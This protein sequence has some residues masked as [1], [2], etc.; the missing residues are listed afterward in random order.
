ME[1]IERR[2]DR[3]RVVTMYTGAGAV[4]YGCERTNDARRKRNDR[5]AG[6]DEDDET[7]DDATT[8]SRSRDRVERTTDDDRVFT[9]S[10]A[11]SR[12]CIRDSIV[13]ARA[14]SPGLDT[15]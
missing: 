9:N 5:P 4:D 8:E 15:R 13:R 3:L 12:A 1:P 2:G 10:R 7:T 6:G 14:D 11:S